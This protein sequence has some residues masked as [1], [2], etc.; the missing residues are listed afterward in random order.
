MAQIVGKISN[1]FRCN[2]ASIQSGGSKASVVLSADEVWLIDTT[3]SLTAGYSGECDA[4]IVGDG[5]TAAGSLTLNRID[6]EQPVQSSKKGTSSGG[7]YI[8]LNGRSGEFSE[9]TKIDGE[10]NATGTIISPNSYWHSSPIAVKKGDVVYVKRQYGGGVWQFVK[11]D[12][13]GGF[14][15]GLVAIVSGT[16]E[17]TY[18]AT[19]DMYISVCYLKSSSTAYRSLL[20]FT[21]A[22]SGI[23]GEIQNLKNEFSNVYDDIDEIDIKI[24]GTTGDVTGYTK[25]D[26]E[27]GQNGNIISESSYWHSSPI[28]LNKGETIYAERQY[29]GN[30]WQF[31]Q[32]DS[33]GNFIK[34]LVPITDSL[35]YS[36]T[37]RATIYVS[38]CYLK[39]TSTTYRELLALTI[40]K[41]SIDDKFNFLEA[42][43]RT[44]SE[45]INTLEEDLAEAENG[46]NTDA[47]YT[48]ESGG[49]GTGGTI[50]SDNWRSTP[51]LLNKGDVIEMVTTYQGSGTAI[52]LTNSN[53]D[54]Y[55]P[56][57]LSSEKTAITGGYKC[58]Y[59][60]KEDCY[61]AVSY[62][63][64]GST[65]RELTSLKITRGGIVGSVNLSVANSIE[66]VGNK[67]SYDLIFDNTCDIVDALY[68]SNDISSF[69]NAA[70]EREKML[71]EV[72]AMTNDDILVQGDC[73]YYD[74]GNGNITHGTITWKIYKNGIL[75]I[76][77]YGKFYDFIKGTSACLNIAQV[78]ALVSSMGS[79]FWYYGFVHGNVNN[80]TPPFAE[81]AQVYDTDEVMHYSGKRY[82]PNGE[83]TNPMNNAPYGYAAPW[84]IY[85][86]DIDWSY[87]SHSVYDQHNPNGIKYDRICIKEDT[88]NGGIT[89]IGNW[90]FY[91]ACVDSLILPA[92]AIKIGCWGVRYSPTMRTLVMGDLVTEIED[93]GVS[94][95]EALNA[96][97]ISNAL[98][99]A[100]YGAFCMNSCLTHVSLPA[101]TTTIGTMLV[102]GDS[103]LEKL[104]LGSATAIPYQMTASCSKLGRITIPSTVTSIANYGVPSSKIKKVTIPSS[105][106]SIGSLAFGARTLKVVTIDGQDVLD[107]QTDRESNGRLLMYAWRVLIKS[108]LTISDYIARYFDKIGEY[109]G[110]DVY[111]RAWDGIY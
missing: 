87:Q 104:E 55:R 91:R 41:P 9:Y 75:Y 3:N 92:N 58:S 29:G 83:N 100:G 19:E 59:L 111:D 81:S 64:N 85:R 43:I 6:D 97:H 33:S 21:I 56:L 77:G 35:E 79:D 15:Q 20:S 109:N 84:Y 90:T 74:D 65:P 36:Y 2:L 12:S 102:Q 26:G 27:Y 89:Y 52:A 96:L 68:Q 76:E 28:L 49:I 13:S 73:G 11:V 24:D 70:F 60:A 108:T 25:I 4:Y 23:Y 34:G 38:V 86:T 16:L 101:A 31:V 99:T 17:Y 63:S 106:L 88:T 62:L 14:L 37:T 42:D 67:E 18:T 1:I 80:I 66:S 95:H 46:T 107:A 54:W 39:A 51:I 48:K 53:E 105:V 45:D 50:S 44:N 22:S 47:V 5:A 32:V 98:V 110:Y 61:I 72:A 71:T 7:M 82:V 10:Y 57:V 8:I 78:N 69:A 103:S 30:Y 94:R 40:T 93:H